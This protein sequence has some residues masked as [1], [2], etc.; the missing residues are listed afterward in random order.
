MLSL[1]PPF[2][3]PVEKAPQWYGIS[4]DTAQRGLASLVQYGVLK[5][6]SIP[7]LAPL[8]P[9]GVT[10]DSRCTLQGVFYSDWGSSNDN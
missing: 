7:K 10:Y 2:I 9:R 6:A 8:A 4:A 3:L 1:R 5:V